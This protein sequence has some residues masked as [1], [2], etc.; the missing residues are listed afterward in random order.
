MLS[1]YLNI[2]CSQRLELAWF[3]ADAL[4]QEAEK[5]VAAALAERDQA[6]HDLQNAQSRHGEEIE[7]R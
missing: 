5:E 3:I 2:W 1:F 6:I 7:A 4:N